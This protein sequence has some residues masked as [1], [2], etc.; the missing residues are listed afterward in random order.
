MFFATARALANIAVRGCHPFGVNRVRMVFPGCSLPAF[1]QRFGVVAR[2]GANGFEPF[3]FEAATLGFCQRCGN[4][5]ASEERIDASIWSPMRVF[6]FPS[7]V[8]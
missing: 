2:P 5:A 3:G 6:A 1:A 4:G 7:N 8:L